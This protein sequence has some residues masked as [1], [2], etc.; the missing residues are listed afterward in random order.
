MPDALGGWMSHPARSRRRGHPRTVVTGG[1]RF[2][3]YGRISTAEYQDP[4]SSR[5]WQ[6][7]NA[8]R[9]I[10]GRGV[11]VADFFD[12]GFHARW[13]RRLQRL[14][15]D[16]VAARHVRWM[17]AQRLAGDGVAGITLTLN[18]TGVPAPSA[19]DPG[20][21]PHRSGAG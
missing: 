11:I 3:F 9:L 8:L 21:H 6:R 7:E 12:V 17:F 13:G 16:P 14:D 4:V 2:A 15:A 5:Q 10:A 20:R 19:H 18:M 1:L